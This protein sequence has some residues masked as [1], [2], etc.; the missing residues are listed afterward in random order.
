MATRSAFVQIRVTP[1]EKATLKSLA[2]SAGQDL[3]TY[4][5]TRAL[6]KPRLRFLQLVRSLADEPEYRFVLAELNDLLT[7]LAPVEFT[8]AIEEADLTGISPLLRNYVAA[9]V[10]QAAYLKDLSPPA[11]T[12][13]VHALDRPFFTSELKSHR[14]HLLRASP[15]P[16]KRRNLFVDAAIGARV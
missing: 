10:E 9:M 3:S 6:P 14:L 12:R 16:F 1:R 11:W 13:S 7:A 2:E 4:I 5:L 15:P 8:D